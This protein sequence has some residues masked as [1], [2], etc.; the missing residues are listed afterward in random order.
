MVAVTIQQAG[1]AL[2]RLDPES[3]AL[4]DLNLRRGMDENEIAS[5]LNVDA[6]EVCERRRRLLEQLSTDLGL[7]SREERD[8]LQATLP[9]LPP[10]VWN[11]SN[12]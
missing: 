11:G 5:V 7:G 2:A 12:G 6:D 8:E 3:R 9:D 10:H 1:D 4:L